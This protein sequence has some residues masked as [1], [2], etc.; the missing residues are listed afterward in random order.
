MRYVILH[1]FY[2]NL[3][4]II[5]LIKRLFKNLFRIDKIDL[6][7][8]NS[9]LSVAEEAE[10]EIDV[11][12][13]LE[14][15]PSLTPERTALFST[16]AGDSTINIFDEFLY[17]RKIRHDCKLLLKIGYDV[18]VVNRSN[19]YG[20]LAMQELLRMKRK[21]FDF[22]ICCTNVSGEHNSLLLDSVQRLVLML[23]CD[24][25]YPTL[26]PDEF[27]HYVIR[28]VTAISTEENLFFSHRKIPR[29]T[30]DYYESF[31]Y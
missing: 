2:Y 20:M 13:Y 14:R 4:Y 16:Y 31:E 23:E 19:Q 24:E 7:A 9:P 8:R 3:R 5:K 27:I 26:F 10:L 6:S 12:E 17:C 15:K 28:C 29:A 30:Y 25:N 21:R 22:R 11:K 1:N 18:F